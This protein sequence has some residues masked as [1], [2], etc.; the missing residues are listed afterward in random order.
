[1]KDEFDALMARVRE[2]KNADNL[3]AFLA[4][5]RAERGN[6]HCDALKVYIKGII[7]EQYPHL[8]SPPHGTPEKL[9]TRVDSV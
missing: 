2:F 6:E 8:I 1:M 4:Q 9:I 5:Y 3:I 7:S